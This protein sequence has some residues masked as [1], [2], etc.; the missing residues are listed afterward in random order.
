MIGL[1]EGRRQRDAANQVTL[2]E[3][4]TRILNLNQF[5]C[6]DKTQLSIFG[7]ELRWLGLF[8]YDPFH[9]QLEL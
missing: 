9:T 1:W 3:H 4:N 7:R 8:R 5:N 6:E 2:Q